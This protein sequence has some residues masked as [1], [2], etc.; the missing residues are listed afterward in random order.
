MNM[1]TCSLGLSLRKEISK[2]SRVESQE[3]LNWEA[4][5]LLSS[6]NAEKY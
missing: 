6:K 2:L 1:T 4:R 3:N 5:A